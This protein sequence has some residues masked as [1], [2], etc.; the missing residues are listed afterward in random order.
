MRIVNWKLFILAVIVYLFRLYSI[1][2]DQIQIPA[3]SRVKVVARISR[4]PTLNASNQIITLGSFLVKTSRLPGYDYGQRLEIIGKPTKRLINSFKSEFIFDYPSIRVLDQGGSLL[5]Q[6]RLRQ[7]LFNIRGLLEQRLNRAL[8]VTQ[9]SLLS[10]ILLGTKSQ[11]PQYF[12][13]NLRQTGTIHIVVA[14]GYNLSVIAGLLMALLLR[15]T[16]RRQAA[17]LSIIGIWLYA[18]M[19]GME[20]PIARAAIMASFAFLAQILGRDKDTLLGLLLAA[21]LILLIS[22]LI[23]FDIGFQLSFMATAGILLISPRLT[24]KVYELPVV[25]Q[26]LRTTLAAQI[27]VLPIILANFGESNWLS[28]IIN[29]LILPAVPLAMVLGLI[30]VSLALVSRLLALVVAWLVWLPLTYIISLINW[31]AGW[32]IGIFWLGRIP[33]SL[34][35]G[36]YLILVIWIKNSKP[37]SSA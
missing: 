5:N 18:L 31:F 8:P 7:L 11:L 13:Q 4:Q 27:A 15:V 6:T 37:S 23:L 2:H 30:L 19:V 29:A 20:A 36:Y 21:L 26:D 9:A 24:G 3:G 32:K 1:S 28:P 12:L 22:P 14:S 16:G 33:F 34:M 17:V 25:G 35:I 10:G